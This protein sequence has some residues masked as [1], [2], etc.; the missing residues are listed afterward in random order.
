[1]SNE[2]LLTRSRLSFRRFQTVV[3][4]NF[5]SSKGGG[6]KEIPSCT[7][8]ARF[9][10][11]QL[12][13]C[14]LDP[15]KPEPTVVII[16]AGM[17]GL[18]AAHRLAQCGLQNFTILEATDRPGGRIH[19]CWLGDV[20]AEMGATWIEGG[21]VANPVF[22]LAAQ[23]GLLKSPLSRPDPSRG[24]FFTSDGRAIDLPVSITAYHTFRQI[25]QQAATL[26]S[27]GC[28]RT[29]G[30]L[31][32]FMGV[33][34]QQELH[35]FPEEQRYDA[36]RVMYGMT[37]CVRCRCGDDL[38]LVSADQ[39]GSYIEIPGGNVRVPL[40]YVGVLAPLLR[41]LPSCC[42]KYCKPVSCIR[43]GAISDSC[44]RA[45]VKCCDGEEFPADYVIV[46]VSLGVLKHQHDKLFCP[47]LPAEKV[48]AIC[49]LGYGYV[50][51]VFL[52]YA[53]PFWVWKEGGIK[54]AWS[55]DELADRCDWVKG[56]S[57]VEELSTSQHVL[58][59]WVCGREAADMELCSDEE[60]VES[61]TRVL[62]QFTGDPTLPY[63]ANLLRSKW[64]M[65]Q[66]FAG[67]YS[68]MGMD[69][70]VGHQCDLAS[71]LPGT[72]EPIPPILL[73]AG[74]ATIPGHYST[75]HGARLSGIREAERIIQLTKRFGGPPKNTAAKS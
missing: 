60:V 59:A 39:F 63:P 28:G 14:M 32:N 72:C 25:E 67:S 10:S 40:G 31:L 17:A 3:I 47:A 38:S 41:D 24:L 64:C 55:A 23:E 69:S 34:I 43:W 18:S 20:V 58:C 44:P 73:F 46:T 61:I 12:D 68:Y 36:A 50:N 8:V 1:M 62:R 52:E 35:N 13:P 74:E 7:K 53:R 29:H 30:T 22:T 56:I 37:N 11:C 2:M 5:A 9:E 65:D 75:V 16:G 54:F 51:K 66:Y 21:C 71:P 48:E 49:K 33:R 70:T 4:R 27:L 26:F 45:V 6:D 19:S 15:C 42:L 57:N